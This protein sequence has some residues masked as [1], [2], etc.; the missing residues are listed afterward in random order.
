MLISLAICRTRSSVQ[1]FGPGFFEKQRAMRDSGTGAESYLDFGL[2]FGAGAGLGPS[3]AS[4]FELSSFLF[5]L[6][7]PTSAHVQS[8]KE[9]EKQTW[10]G[11]H[12]T[13]LRNEFYCP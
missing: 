3:S 9:N 6:L 2:G 12:L 11:K 4:E 10:H 13:V 7:A 5:L 8:V 1:Q